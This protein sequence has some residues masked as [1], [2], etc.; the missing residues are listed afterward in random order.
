M[1]LQPATRFEWERIVRRC[2]IP[3]PTK[4]VGYTLAQYGDKEGA[5]IRPGTPRLAAVCEMG[6]RTVERQVKALR[7]M[8]LVERVS[9]GGG[10]SRRAAEYRLT[11]PSDLLDRVP[12]LDP[13]E[14]TPATYMAG[15]R[16]VDNLHSPATQVA[17]VPC[18]QHPE[19]PPSQTELPPSGTELPPSG[20]LTPANDPPLTCNNAHHQETK[21]LSP[22]KTHHPQSPES[23]PHLP[24]VDAYATAHALLA[25][26]PDLGASY[27][28]KAEA[29]DGL[30]NRVIAAA[31]IATTENPDLGKNRATA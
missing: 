21:S 7:T 26:L 20:A 4:L 25:S 27:M 3:G 2:L 6:T 5:G 23:Q 9:N 10:P 28:A 13:D 19:L 12:L 18:G 11:V 14:T 1:E 24:R 16:P 22:P 31:A 17:L 29:I 15:V 8:G 30:K